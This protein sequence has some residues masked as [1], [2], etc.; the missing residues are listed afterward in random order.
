MIIFLTG[1]KTGIFLV[2]KRFS[3]TN[4]NMTI[5]DFFLKL[6]SIYYTTIVF[7]AKALY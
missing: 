1:P 7:Q 3:P 4:R 6:L 5:N 2:Y